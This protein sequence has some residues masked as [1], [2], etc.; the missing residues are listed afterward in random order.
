MKIRTDA[1]M[2][3][4]SH[5]A[6]GIAGAVA[7]EIGI[8]LAD[9]LAESGRNFVLVDPIGAA[10]DDQHGAARFGAEDQRFRDLG[11]SAADRGGGFGGA[12]RRRRHHPHL[13][14][15]ARRPQ[16]LL[17]ALRR[18]RQIRF[19]QTRL[20]RQLARARSG[21]GNRL[22]EQILEPVG[23]HQHVER[24]K[25]GAGRAGDI[26]AQHRSRVRP[27]AVPTRRRRKPWRGPAASPAPR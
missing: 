11:H 15:R 4:G 19:R 14:A 25:G 2:A 10:R 21:R 7:H 13:A 17:D 6:D 24:R 22:D 1:L 3:D 23:R 8:G 12:A 18:R 5:P 20:L 26:L 16:L 27:K 9:R